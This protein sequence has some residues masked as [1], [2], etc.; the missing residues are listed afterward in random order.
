MRKPKKISKI[1]NTDRIKLYFVC[2]ILILSTFLLG[3]SFSKTNTN[4]QHQVIAKPVSVQVDVPTR[5]LAKG[6]KISSVPFTKIEWPSTSDISQYYNVA[7]DKGDFFT[8]QTFSAFSPIPKGALTKSSSDANAVVEGIPSG[9][10]AIT[11]RVDVE[12]IVEGW[13]QAGNFVD[14]IVLRQ[15]VDEDLLTEA[16]LAPANQDADLVLVLGPPDRMPE[17]MVWELA[18]CE[19]VFIDLDWS[20]FTAN[21]LELAIDD[22]NRRHRRF[23]GLDS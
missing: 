5:P 9:Y 20:A 10:R 22:F 19:I 2:G 6:Q 4:S 23:G 1:S 13:A 16:L 21:H 15:S 8:S 17:S 7:N 14:V 18:Y 12:S 11:V 3:Y